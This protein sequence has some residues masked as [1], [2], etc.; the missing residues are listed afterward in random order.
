MEQKRKEKASRQAEWDRNFR[1]AQAMMKLMKHVKQSF[2]ENVY[3]VFLEE[4]L[5][6]GIFESQDLLDEF[7]KLNG[8]QFDGIDDLLEAVKDFL[9]SRYE[10]EEE[11]RLE[12]RKDKHKQMAEV[13]GENLV[14]L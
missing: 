7:V 5:V 11:V 12:E 13:L 6:K 8:Y 4:M 3:K 14:F 1:V 9:E 2:I 10:E